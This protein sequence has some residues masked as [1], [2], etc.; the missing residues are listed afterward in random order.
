MSSELL[1]FAFGATLCLL[2]A[3]IAVATYRRGQRERIESPKYR[4]LDDD[5]G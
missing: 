4:M 3:L 5:E 1:Y 2:L